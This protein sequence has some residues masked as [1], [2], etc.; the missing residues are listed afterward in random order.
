MAREKLFTFPKL[1][2][3]CC[4]ILIVSSSSCLWYV[5]HC[6][7]SWDKTTKTM[8]H[9]LMSSLCFQAASH[10]GDLF[11]EPKSWQNW[12]AWNSM[13]KAHTI[14]IAPNSQ[15]PEIE[16]GEMKTAFPQKCLQYWV[17]SNSTLW[18]SWWNYS[19]VL[20]ADLLQT[21]VNDSLS[22]LSRIRQ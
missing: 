17:A 8:V 18:K 7:C 20:C 11:F 12:T 5:F 6:Q 2:Y 1:C 9:A 14:S 19:M 15:T 4:M 10:S 22:C 16:W 21:L 3:F 13:N